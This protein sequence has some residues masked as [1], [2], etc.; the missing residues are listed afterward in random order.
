[1]NAAGPVVRNALKAATKQ[2]V[3]VFDDASAAG[4]MLD[5]PRQKT[6]VTNWANGN[7]AEHWI[8]VRDLIQLEVLAGRPLVT[9]LLCKLNGGLFVPH[10]DLAA[11]EGS[12]GWLV[13][14]LSKEL[15]D[16][17]GAVAEGLSDGAMDPAEIHNACS[18]LDDVDRVSAQLRA[19]F[20]EMLRRIDLAGAGT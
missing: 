11:D 19:A 1:M 3:A 17:S 4:A 7:D 6:S 5:P 16:V 10:I 15:G 9:E 18:Q 2:L 14:R 8:G 12:A 13:M 20:A